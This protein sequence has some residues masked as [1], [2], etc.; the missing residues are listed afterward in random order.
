MDDSGYDTAME[1]EE[2]IPAEFAILPDLS[3]HHHEGMNL[4]SKTMSS[5]LLLSGVDDDQ[6]VSKPTDDGAF[7][8]TEMNLGMSLLYHPD[9]YNK[10]LGCGQPMFDVNS[11]RMISFREAALRK[12]HDMVQQFQ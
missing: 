4:T 2:F 8:D 1:E 6:I 10:V 12:K 11:S 5:T 7:I 3:I 9:L